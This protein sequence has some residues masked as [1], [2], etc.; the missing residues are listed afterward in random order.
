MESK[1]QRLKRAFSAKR[2]PRAQRQAIDDLALKVSNVGDVVGTLAPAPSASSGRSIELEPGIALVL[3]KD[4]VF[5]NVPRERLSEY[6]PRVSKLMQALKEQPG[7][8]DDVQLIALW[9]ST[10]DQ[11]TL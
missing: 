10:A 9:R 5:V 2:E 4:Q 8:V 1:A 3:F 7:S 6:T 11:P